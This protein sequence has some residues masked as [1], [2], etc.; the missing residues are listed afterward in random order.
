MN[1]GISRS[2]H[3][4]ILGQN[5]YVVWE[6]STLGN[7]EIYFRASNDGGQT[8]GE[9]QNLSNNN[10]RSSDSQITVSS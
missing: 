1:N 4:A 6:D 7:K 9:T 10:K 8:F 3:I 5:V 2:P